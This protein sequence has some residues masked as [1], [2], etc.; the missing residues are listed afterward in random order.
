MWN[1][2]TYLKNS[3]IANS[4]GWIS[5]H[6]GD[7]RFIILLQRTTSQQ[8]STMFLS[9]QDAPDKGL[10]YLGMTPEDAIEEIYRVSL[11]G[12]D[13]HVW[14]KKGPTLPIDKGQWSKKSKHGA[15]KYQIVLPVHKP[16]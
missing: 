8:P 11:D 10:Q 5:S 9:V 6:F 1:N 7:S 12:T 15:F 16:K 2:A 4:S 14:E 3:Q 13:F